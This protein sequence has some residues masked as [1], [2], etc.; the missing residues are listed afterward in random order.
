[1]WTHLA[2]ELEFDGGLL[3]I[4]ER[5]DKGVTFTQRG[6]FDKEYGSWSGTS[7]HAIT[8]G[9]VMRFYRKESARK[10]SFAG[11][12]CKHFAYDFIAEVFDHRRKG[13][14]GNWCRPLEW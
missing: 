8:M 9:E 14:F 11:K 5:T 2:V 1:M 3:A 13:D 6:H 12:N 4:L 10:Y 7:V